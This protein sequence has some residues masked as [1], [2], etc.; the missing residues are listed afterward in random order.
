MVGLVTMGMFGGSG[1]G[2]SE[3]VEVPVYGTG[4]GGFGGASTFP[5]IFVNF[6][7]DD[8]DLNIEVK[9]ILVSEDK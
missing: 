8:E 5:K 7:E 4:G 6:E 1:S 3:I 2:T 9:M